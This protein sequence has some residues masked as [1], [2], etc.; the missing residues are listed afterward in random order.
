MQEAVVGHGDRLSAILTRKMHNIVL[1]K[2]SHDQLGVEDHGKYDGIDG[3][4]IASAP[5]KDVMSAG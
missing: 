1:E 2:L 4:L 3:P 5:V